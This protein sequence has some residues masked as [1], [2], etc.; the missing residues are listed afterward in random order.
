MF[1]TRN[2]SLP[3]LEEAQAQ[4]HVTVNDALR[5]IDQIVQL[6]VISRTLSSAPISPNEG[7]R[8][9]VAPNGAG[10]WTDHDM[11]VAAYIDGAWLFFQPLPGWLA[12]VLSENAVAYWS[13]EAWELLQEVSTNET[14]AKFA[15]NGTADTYNRL[16]TR[17]R[18][19]LFAPDTTQASGGVRIVASKSDLSATTSHLFQTN[20]SS[21]AEFG[22]LAS[23]DFTLKVSADGTTFRQSFTVDRNTGD[24][25]FATM[26][27]VAGSKG[28]AL[29]IPSHSAIRSARVPADT[30]QLSTRG[31]TSE[32]D[33]GG[34]V[35]S[36]VAALPSD[37]LGAVDAAGGI[38]ALVGDTVTARQAGAVGNGIDDDTESLNAAFRSGRTVLIEKGTYLI[39]DAISTGA[40]HQRI[41][42]EGRGRSILKVATNFN[43][44]ASAALR[45]VHSFVS[46]SDIQINYDQSQ[47]S[48]RAT[49]VRYPPAISLVNQT[50]C[51]LSRVRLIEAWDGIDASGNTGGAIFQDVE[52]GSFNVGFRLGGA[53][54]TVEMVDCRVWPFNFS[55][56]PVLFGIY[57]DGQTVGF[58]IGR[59]DDLKMSNCTPFQCRF[60]V[61]ATSGIGPFGT[62]NGLALDGSNSRIEMSAGDISINSLY[63]TSAVPNDYCIL[64]TSGSLVL[65][66]FSFR[67]EN[68]ANQPLV[69]V[70]GVA[71]I[72]QIANGKCDLGASVAADG[73]LVTAGQLS[74]S[75]VRFILSGTTVRTGACV[76]QTGGTVHAWGNSCTPVSAGSGAF[77]SVATNGA[78]SVVGNHSAGWA[79]ALPL[80]TSLGVFGPNHNGTTTRFDS[81]VTFGSIHSTGQGGEIKLDG[82]GFSGPLSFGNSEG[83]ARISGLASGKAFQVVMPDGVSSID[84]SSVKW[85]SGLV[86]SRGNNDD[87]QSLAF[88]QLALAATAGG[89]G[90]VAIG[91]RALTAVDNGSENVAIGVNAAASLAIGNGNTFVGFNAGASIVGSGNSAVG[92]NSFAAAP[93]N[94]SNCTAI[95]DG[96]T[97]NGANQI[98]LGNSLTTTY[99]YGAV[100]NRSDARDKTDVRD[101]VLGSQLHP[102]AAVGGLSLGLPRG[103]STSCG[104]C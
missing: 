28:L 17:S 32:N 40:N 18:G 38:W 68:F 11:D 66:D 90:N 81:S 62:I 72:C 49:L 3:F 41:V 27:L 61:E 97:V 55:D 74:I 77:I 14:V 57:Q 98:Q 29:S 95:G 51:R 25:E 22:L 44:S 16:V 9:L 103:L 2:L 91:R 5:R 60:L 65:S 96:A 35:Y 67:V 45:V 54:D 93:A 92:R 102:W 88:G 26:P 70:N 82:T 52:S 34:G 36:R 30:L 87:N 43:L 1:N 59:V 100:I 4:K 94:I 84:A 83:N 71:A 89:T 33:G 24:V 80:S 12:F 86:V 73:F 15:I 48:S 21:R 58:K 78:H 64:Q 37:G 23:D 75:G 47:A 104:N 63:C 20:F 13:G 8:Y 19:V 79:Y 85:S 6:S 50:R 7:D 101:S 31:Y 69:H 42:G 10:A 46:V 39:R 56:K 99:T 76:K 53:L